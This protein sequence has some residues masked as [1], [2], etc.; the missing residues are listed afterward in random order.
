MSSGIHQFLENIGLPQH[1]AAFMRNAVEIDLLGQVDD[2]VLQDIGIA[3]NGHRL[4]ILRAITRPSSADVATAGA[5]SAIEPRGNQQ[6]PS[7]ANA[8]R[9]QLTVMFC[10][11]VGASRLAEQLDP[12]EL[13]D[14]MQEY[15]HVCGDVVARYE[16]HV[17]QY[18]GDG[19]VVY[20]G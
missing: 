6:F 5:A 7:A 2:Q 19:L 1:A 10:D 17:A 9:R 8:E 11:L 15:Q 3:S 20:Y 14:I 18:R 13:R 16:G 12:E 4:R